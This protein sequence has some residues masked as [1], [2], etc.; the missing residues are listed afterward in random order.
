MKNICIRSNAFTSYRNVFLSSESKF[1][2]FVDPVLSCRIFELISTVGRIQ[3]PGA[4][5][6]QN[7]FKHIIEFSF[8]I[9]KNIIKCFI[10]HL[11]H[12]YGR[13]DIQLDLQEIWFSCWALHTTHKFVITC[14]YASFRLSFPHQHV[15]AKGIIIDYDL[16]YFT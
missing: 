1:F 3:I 8:F 4:K 2:R 16:N 6:H 10:K 13:K 14:L 12:P 9:Q 15:A 5:K 11:Y 7:I